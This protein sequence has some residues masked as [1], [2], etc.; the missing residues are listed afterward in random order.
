MVVNN[1]TVKPMDE[2]TV[3]AAAERCGRV[4]TVEEHQVAAGMGSAVAEVLARKY[5]VPIEFVGM[6]DRF[7]ESGNPHELLKHFGLDVAGIK[8]AVSRVL[9]RKKKR[10]TQKK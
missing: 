4:V 2:A 5:P 7:G 1:H 9:K 10:V 6:Q 3:V 8:E